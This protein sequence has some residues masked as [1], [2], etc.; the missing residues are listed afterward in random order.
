MAVSK[1]LVVVLVGQVISALL[2]VT[3][4]TSTRLTE[5]G[6]FFP[7][8]Q[9]TGFYL[10]LS[11]CLLKLPF[12]LKLPVLLYIAIAVL[13]VEANFLAVKAYQYTDI[14]SILLLNSLT[15]PWTVLLSYLVFKRKYR[16]KQLGC[17][18]V[19]LA[20]LG[21]II[22]SDTIRGRWKHDAKW[23]SAWKGDLLC[24]GSSFL[25]ASQNVMQEYVLKKL[26]SKDEATYAEYLGMLGMAGFVI[27]T[28]QWLVVE[29]SE[30][31]QAWP[32]LWKGEVIGLLVGF[33]FTMVALYF[34]LAWYISRFDASV[35]N[36]NILTSGIYG[37]V[38]SFIAGS[39]KLGRASDWMYTLAYALIV[40]G[41]VLYSWL[42]MS[43]QP[44]ESQ[45]EAVIDTGVEKAI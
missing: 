41:V 34:L 42:E 27:S 22:A 28:I 20:G 40:C 7:I 23:S 2:A 31:V 13:D 6:F 44:P 12:P 24:V 15:I 21:L 5:N 33:S 38:I 19:C 3:G 10:V 1:P 8:L 39:Q 35:F 29:R 25:Y 4:F 18:A 11:L 26:R 16:I 36:M 30:L 37:I 9:S 43:E 32:D 17:I 14:T 45:I